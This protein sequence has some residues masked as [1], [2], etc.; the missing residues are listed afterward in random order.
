VLDLNPSVPPKLAETIEKALEKDRDLRCQTA[1]ELKADLKRLR[2]DYSSGKTASVAGSGEHTAVVSSGQVATAPRKTPSSAEV[3]LG[4]ARRNK[5]G[6]IMAGFVAVIVLGILGWL[7]YSRFRPRPSPAAQMSI[8]RLTHDGRTNGS[9]SISPDGKYVVYEVTR[10]SKLSLWLRQIASSSAVKLVPD[11]D[12]GFGGTTFSPDGNFVYYQRFSKEDP[13]GALY[14]VP[15]LGGAPRRVLSNIASPVTFSPDGKQLAFVRENSAQGPT[16]QI[17]VANADGSDARPIATGKVGVDWFEIHGPS[18][19]PDGKYIAVGEEHLNSSG[20]SN[21]ISLLDMSGKKTTLVERLA[22][23][24]ARLL[25]LKSG[26]GLVFSATPR[27]GATYSQLWYVSYPG[28]EV[29]R[30]T[31]DLNSYGQLSLGVTADSSTLVT[32]QSI[33]HSNLWVA[34][35]NYKDATQITQAEGDGTDG[36]AA[37]GGKVAYS[38]TS[39]GVAAVA[40]ANLDGSGQTQVSPGEEFCIHPAISRDGHHVGLTCF[41]G[42]RPNIWVA[43]TDGSDFRQLTFG[44]ADLEPA[45]S[46][47]GTLV[48]FQHW[49]EGKVHVWKVAF[50]GGQPAQVSNLQIGSHSLSH[51]GD[52]ILAEYFDDQAAQWK[53][54]I[55]S[56]TDGKLL[57]PVDISIATQFPMFTPDDKGLLYGETHNSVTNV[58]KLSLD[59]GARTQVTNFTSDEIFNAAITPDGTLVMA[60]GHHHTDA[61]LVRNFH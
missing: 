38:T 4:E 31:N 27:M 5:T 35:G 37:A 51:H 25:W 13:N 40:S 39:T 45:F 55:V 48:Y 43:D 30:I 41:Q 56:T 10:D 53:M 32:V 7:L 36:L 22:G 8:E 57:G 52:R 49:S 3:L 44:N 54:G 42:G 6:V 28:G 20:Y 26:D 1:A 60:R 15:T 24:I 46:P 9:T 58:W 47:D 12:D 21:G 33:P 50:A 16:S 59:T 2:R 34:K 29:S 19:S 14:M 18:W 11:T 17:V 23:K 61:I